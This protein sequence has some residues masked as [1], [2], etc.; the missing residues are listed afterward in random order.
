ME[1]FQRSKLYEYKANSNLV[2]EADRD[3]RRRSD[4]GKGEVESLHS[5]LHGVRMGDRIDRD[6]RPD[7]DDRIEKSRQKRLRDAAAA[8]IEANN[9]KKK[10]GKS[11][12]LVGHGSVLTETEDLDSLNYRPKTRESKIAYEEILSFVQISLGDQPQDI[13][14]GAT[15]EVL[16]LLKDDTIRDPERQ[17]EI[18]KILSNLSNEKFNKLVN[19]GKRITDFHAPGTEAEN[20]DEG[21]QANKMNEDMGV[22]VVFDDEEDGEDGE[23]GI[24]QEVEL[25]EIDEM[26]EE[27]EGGEEATGS[28]VLKGEDDDDNDDAM[29]VG[30]A[31]DDKYKLSIHDIDAHWLQRQLSKYYTDANVSAKMAEETLQALQT[32]NDER[33][34]ENK[35]VVLLDFDKFDFIKLLLR[36]RAKIYYCTRLKQAQSD[37]ERSNIEEEMQNDINHGGPQILQQLNQKA[38]A[39]SWTQ[40]RIGEF[41]NKARREA[42]ALNKK[43]VGS[44]G[45]SSSLQPDGDI[46]TLA[47]IS[48]ASTTTTKASSAQGKAVTAERTLDLDSLQFRQGGHLMTNKRCELPEKSWRAQKKGYEEV[49][50]PAIRPIV[51]KSE[52]MTEISEL[53]E[54]MRPA[55]PGIRALNRVQSKMVN[56]SLYGS[57]NLLLCAP[58]GAGKTN[59]AL[60]CMLNQLALHRKDDGTFD[61]NA[62]K[63]VYVAPMKALVQ[64]CVQSFG[65][66]LEPFGVNVRELS[67]DQNLTRQQ[68]QDTQVIVTTPEKWDIITRK[69]GDRTYTQ[70]VRLIIIDEIHLLHDDRGPVLESLVARTIRQVEATQE[71]V[72]LVG[73]SATLPNYE[74]VA[75]FLRVDPEK[76]LFYFDNSYRP[77]PLQQQYIGITEKKA[78]KRFQLMNEIC[79][80]KVL[81]Q[82]GKNQVLIFTHSRAETAKTARALRDMALENDALNLFVRDD[83]ASREILRE[84]AE[85]VKNQDLK[86]LLPYGFA[87]HHA[88]M[89]RSDRTLVE[90]LFSD[91]HIQVLVSTATLAWGVNLPCHTVILKGT[92][93][94][95]PEQGRWVELSPLDIMQ[96][97]GRAGRYGLDT[98]GEGIIMTAHSEL[99]YY[100]SLMNQQLPIESQFI[101][102]LPDL[103]N[104]EVVLGSITTIREAASWLGYTYLY[105]RMLKN[106]SVYGISAEEIERDPK[107][108]Q[109][110]LDLAHT[111]ASILDKHNLLK[112]DRK[113]A[114]FQVTTLGRVASYYYVS[115]ES[116]NVFNEYLKP[117]MTEIEIF[118]LFSLSGE[119][120]NIHVRE[121]EKLELM[122]LLTRVPI[123]IK[124]GIEEP[125]AKVN[126][127]LQ[128]Y[129]SRLKLDGFALM[130][131]MAYIQQSACRLFRALFEVALKRGWSSL[132]CKTLSICKMVERRIWGSQSPLRQFGAIPEVIIRKLEKV[133]G[134][135]TW[136][137]YYDLKP[138]DLGEMVKIPKMGKTLHKYV[139]MFPKLQL[140]TH[141]QPIT[142]SLLKID[143]VITPDFQFDAQVHDSAQMFWI[144]VEDVD[145][146][147][148]LH[149]ET[150]NLR[151]QYA[152]EEHM[153]TF[154]VPMFE[155]FPPQYFIKVIS[156]RWLHSEAVLPVSFRHLILPS[157]FPPAT[158]LLDLQPLPVS[159]LA[160]SEGGAYRSLFKGLPFRHFN[161]IQTQTYST[162]YESDD[163]VL[164]CAPTGSGKTLCAE[165][166]IL[167]LFNNAKRGKGSGKCVYIAPKQAIA[168]VM[169][170]TWSRRFGELLGK[171]VVQLTGDITSDL[172]LLEAG[173]IVIAS[174]PHW[175]CTS[176][177]WRQRKQVQNVALYI[178]GELHLIGGSDGPT[179]E[180]VVSRIRFAASQLEKQVRIVG[181]SSSLANAKDVG[182]WMGVPSHA[183]Y[184]FSPDCR[185]VPLEIHFH[186]FETAHFGTR[187]LSMAKPAYNAITTLS[188]NK[189]V[190]VFVPSRKQAQ[191]SA[192][193]IITYAA[194]SGH[195]NRF[196]AEEEGIEESM[197]AVVKTIKEPVLAQTLSRGVGF[198]HPALAKS[199]RKRVEGLYRDGV[200]SVLVCPYD[201]CWN[202]PGPAHLVIVMDTVYYDGREHRFVDY[203]ITEVLQMAGM[204]CRPTLDDSGKC[205]VLCHNPKKE[206]LKKLLYDPLPVESHL[207]HFL[208]D[209]LNAEIVTKTIESKEDAVTYLTWT[210]FYKRLMQNPN[211][212]SLQGTTNRH[213]SD[214][215]SELIESSVTDLEESKCIS[216]EDDM[217]LSPLNLGMIAS[218][219]Y[220]QY[221]TVELYASSLTAKTKIKGLL[222]I[223]SA[224]SEYTSLSI[225]QSEGKQLQEMARRLPFSL[226]DS[227]KYEDPAT[228]TFLLLQSHFCRN[229]LPTDLNTDLRFILSQAIKL[230]QALV[231]V[232]SSNGWLKPA[233][234]CMELSQMIVQGLWDKD[235]IL[236]QIPHFTM[237]TV[238]QC[239]ALNP[240]VNSVFD[241]LD[242]DDDVRESLLS[243]FKPD[244]VSDIATFCNSYPNIELTFE[245]DIEESG[246][247]MT[248]ESITVTVNIK[249]D[250]DDEDEDEASVSNLGKVVCPR[251]HHEKMESWWVVIGDSN[252]N[253]LLSIKRVAFGK[254]TKT[255]LEFTAPEDPGDYCFKLNLMSDSYMGCDQEYDIN[256]T[257]V[258]DDSMET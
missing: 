141:I 151:M 226:S 40:D 72:R 5:K 133:S 156:D 35:L 218:Y 158:E 88:G 86:D 121:E 76:G 7:L 44:D 170:A 225:R 169:F 80:E 164:V 101:K 210:F 84:E 175:D 93:M 57:E 107:L 111:A 105:V 155:P 246:E 41:A 231:D 83:S 87:I 26:E 247:V 19:L 178:I 185:P 16:L 165:F 61:L 102:K 243:N 194:A 205:V 15:E 198:L 250:D 222:E 81:Q 63:I 90:D 153:V 99:Q 71:M 251:F 13:L 238:A 233:L 240:P 116:I 77:V 200:I 143:L 212:Y 17:R 202:V 221:T 252:S 114:T 104:A 54:W 37:S 147:K 245:T 135:I 148:I 253:A 68:I 25:D 20:A 12:F 48:L 174:A 203:S 60:L 244:Q 1:E 95:N 42:R 220:I 201:L 94:Y 69:A 152:T 28:G 160:S 145:G 236:L 162:L 14:R 29:N 217:D 51:S 207:D 34:C 180:V 183:V 100:L 59:V 56:A 22:A 6:K 4:E 10:A 67:G 36:N 50:V 124:E 134:D 139:H 195:P 32:S 98:E 179:L 177:R 237:D 129:I 142:R 146:E 235:S 215:L 188:P 52:K 79:Y 144:I 219:Y 254:G 256:V 136:E 190:L 117:S 154:T 184:N 199:D 3:L 228:K 137:R 73:L 167:R 82:A 119:F 181:L 97:M 122:K 39:E 109:R 33:V 27:D 23:N 126:V 8:D 74:D 229:P 241:V 78:L 96:M 106:P 161:P 113:A 224:S 216:V 55:F 176:R 128:A 30:D 47:P 132:A 192:I 45:A 43:G 150:F 127:L 232:I 131:D 193:D 168:D 187:M 173:D 85:S 123:P 62:F 110:R 58:T 234:A 182:D 11:N 249:R 186:G 204:A 223:L 214:Y 130:A 157:K 248:G 9:K 227:A 189:P 206:F 115:H 172:K 159:A 118:R 53:P 257:V 38:S 46:D 140:S 211:Y 258:P 75:I 213:L 191:L 230:I 92:Q 197:A 66:K 171:H 89:V 31:A 65:K 21:D 242:L 112:Y 255:K 125:S 239:K 24:G 2:L 18:G 149:Y 166:A 91:K 208:H 70:L 103:L 163:N 138:Q 49:H 209:H 108:L 64:E 120:Q 196:L